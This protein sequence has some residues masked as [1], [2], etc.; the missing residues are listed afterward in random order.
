MIGRTAVV[1]VTGRASGA[2]DGSDHGSLLLLQ[3]LVDSGVG[4]GHGVRSGW[5]LDRWAASVFLDS[6]RV[7]TV[8]ALEDG[9]LQP[10]VGGSRLD[11]ADGDQHDQE[12]ER[13]H[14]AGQPTLVSAAS[15]TPSRR[16]TGP[17]SV[18]GRFCR[19]LWRRGQRT[20]AALVAPR[21]CLRRHVFVRAGGRQWHVSR[22]WQSK[23][24]RSWRFE[25]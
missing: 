12:S 18:N 6:P 25:W 7:R 1:F 24:T 15:P 4:F 21:R 22:H 19:G 9:L 14:Q 10:E 23:R 2:P 8:V 3:Q 20:S 13:P 5:A 16:G 17:G 11:L